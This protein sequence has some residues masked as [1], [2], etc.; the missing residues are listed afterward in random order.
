MLRERIRQIEWRALMKMRSPIKTDEMKE[1][2]QDQS[3]VLP[4]NDQSK[5]N[6]NFN[7]D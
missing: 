5:K 3:V 1:I 4:P 6:N 7:S 2:F